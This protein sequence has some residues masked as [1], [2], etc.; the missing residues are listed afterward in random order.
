MDFVALTHWNWKSNN[1][2]ICLRCETAQ[3]FIVLTD[4]EMV[5]W[6]WSLVLKASFPDLNFKHS[7]WQLWLF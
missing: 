5:E 2:N 6:K 4:W 3:I 1:I 7:N